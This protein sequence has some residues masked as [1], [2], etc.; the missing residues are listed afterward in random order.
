MG[1][2]LSSTALLLENNWNILDNGIFLFNPTH[3]THFLFY[4]EA[5]ESEYLMNIIK[6]MCFCKKRIPLDFSDQ[7][8][9]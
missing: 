6:C 7:R 1:N 3:F 5:F 9:F 2:I 4:V 8:R